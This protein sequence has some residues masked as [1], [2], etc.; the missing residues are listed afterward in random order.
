MKATR[1]CRV[2]R[3]V[4]RRSL[5]MGCTPKQSWKCVHRALTCLE[6]AQPRKAIRCGLALSAA[7]APEPEK[8]ERQQQEVT[9]CAS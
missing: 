8:T 5:A 3:I 6:V 7:L 2:A 1:T 4:L 9:A